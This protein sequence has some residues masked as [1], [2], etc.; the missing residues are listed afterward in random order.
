METTQLKG[1]PRVPSSGQDYIASVSK[2]ANK[3]Q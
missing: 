1:I 2:E 3:G